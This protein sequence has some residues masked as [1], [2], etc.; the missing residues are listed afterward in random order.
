MN[1]VSFFKKDK[2]K[3]KK[4][5][6][7]AQRL[8]TVHLCM[9]RIQSRPLIPTEPTRNDSLLHLTPPLFTGFSRPRH[10]PWFFVFLSSLRTFF[11]FFNLSVLLLDWDCTLHYTRRIMVVGSALV[12][13]C[14]LY[15]YIY[16]YLKHSASKFVCCFFPSFFLFFLSKRRFAAPTADVFL[17]TSLV[18]KS[19]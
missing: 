15:K 12:G 8:H 17:W 10:E 19:R 14:F 2:R 9:L 7:A 6:G 5:L 4:T 11:F 16:I 1:V 18:W 3:E 13:K